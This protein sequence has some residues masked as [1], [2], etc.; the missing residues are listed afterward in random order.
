MVNKFYTYWRA[1]P[2]YQKLLRNI[3]PCSKEDYQFMEWL[4][5]EYD[6]Y[7]ANDMLTIVPANK[8]NIKEILLKISYSGYGYINLVKEVSF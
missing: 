1:E 3:A 6:V 8:E 4:S 7:C 2:M 5:Q